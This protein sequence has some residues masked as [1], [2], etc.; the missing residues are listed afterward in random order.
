MSDD[1]PIIGTLND[2]TG[3]RIGA[4]IAK[5]FSN[6]YIL[7]RLF[8]EQQWYEWPESQ[9]VRVTKGYGEE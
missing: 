7:C 1:R 4:A 6:G 2:H 9:F 8:G 5:S 3:R